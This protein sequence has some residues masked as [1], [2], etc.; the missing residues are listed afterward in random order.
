MKKLQD[1]NIQNK[2][3]CKIQFNTVKK[4]R[5]VYYQFIMGKF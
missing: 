1:K 5:K 4:V 3:K 2:I